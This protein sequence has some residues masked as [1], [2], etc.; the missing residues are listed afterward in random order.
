MTDEEIYP[1]RE[2]EKVAALLQ[3]SKT[4]LTGLQQQRRFLYKMYSTKLPCPLC[5]EKVSYYEAA[6]DTVSIGDVYHGPLIC[7]HC[8]AKLV[9]VVP[10]MTTG[11]GWHWALA[12]D[13]KKELLELKRKS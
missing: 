3:V 11:A 1:N 13:Q 4:L 7:P 12:D 9:K 10:F 5:E 6:D 8:K 2:P